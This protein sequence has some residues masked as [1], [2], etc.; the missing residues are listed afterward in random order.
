MTQMRHGSWSEARVSE[1]E[2]VPAV[3]LMRGALAGPERGP[4]EG[5][6]AYMRGQPRLRR[7]SALI[8]EPR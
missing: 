5:N 6:H 7:A 2:R 4:Y 3:L 8:E 1:Q